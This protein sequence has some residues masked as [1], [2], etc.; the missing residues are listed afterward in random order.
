[1]RGLG[2][3]GADV[4]AG[5]VDV[6]AWLRGHGCR[7]GC[8]EWLRGWGCSGVEVAASGG[9]SWE[10][11][12][13]L[14][15]GHQKFLHAGRGRCSRCSFF[16]GQVS[17]VVELA[18]AA[19]GQGVVTDHNSEACAGVVEVGGFE[20]CMAAGAVDVVVGVDVGVVQAEVHEGFG[21]GAESTVGVERDAGDQVADV[22]VGEV[23][24]VESEEGDATDAID[25]G[26]VVS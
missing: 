16:G 4:V 1:M 25:D 22:V 13:G 11:K 10:E 15:G 24:N 12:V 19:A 3:D 6:I 26:M 17:R 20:D 7:N 9:V 21:C 5:V 18:V 8:R 23:A 14:V 2:A